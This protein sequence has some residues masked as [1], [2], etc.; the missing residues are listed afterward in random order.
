MCIFAGSL[1][2]N[3]TLR[4]NQDGHSKVGRPHAKPL[5]GS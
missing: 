5:F 3:L 1:Y 2:V 4:K